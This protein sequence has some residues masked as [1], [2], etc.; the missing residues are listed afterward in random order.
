MLESWAGFLQGAQAHR[1][2]AEHIEQ[3]DGIAQ[4]LHTQ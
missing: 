2:A 1:A 3:G 4:S